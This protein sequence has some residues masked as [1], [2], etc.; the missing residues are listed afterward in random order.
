MVARARLQ[1]RGGVLSRPVRAECLAFL[2]ALHAVA[3][4]TRA[5]FPPGAEKLAAFALSEEGARDT[6]YRW[7][8]PSRTC[9][10]FRGAGDS[11][12]N[13]LTKGSARERGVDCGRGQGPV[14]S[15]ARYD[16]LSICAVFP[17]RRGLGPSLVQQCSLGALR[18]RELAPRLLDRMAWNGDRVLEALAVAYG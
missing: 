10:R 8:L 13:L 11:S 3:A 2:V 16:P 12:G 15:V 18:R 17:R 6:R 5:P 14:A 9:Q 1:D 7:G 4:E